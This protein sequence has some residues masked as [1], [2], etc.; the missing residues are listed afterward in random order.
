ML[1]RLF[2]LL[3]PRER[4]RAA[5]VLLL[6]LVMAAIEVA[7]IGG[8]AGFIAAVADPKALANAPWIAKLRATLGLG[9]DRD[10]FI[11][12]GIALFVLFIL[13]N[14]AGLLLL[15]YRLHFMHS[16]RRAMTTRLFSYYLSRPFEYFLNVNS[17]ELTRRVQARA[18]SAATS[19]E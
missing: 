14:V 18:T 15:W 13:R 8:I 16:T 1:R 12:A 5:I 17:A 9:G 11:A 6:S 19:T 2:A 10:F 4:R 7:S 3:S